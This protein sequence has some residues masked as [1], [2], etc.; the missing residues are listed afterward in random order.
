MSFEARQ[1]DQNNAIARALD[2]RVSLIQELLD[3][4]R[5]SLDLDQLSARCNLSSSRLQHLFKQHTGT[6]LARYSKQAKLVRAR[7]LVEE[8]F[9]T[10]KQI[11]AIVGFS[12]ISHFVRDYKLRFGQTPSGT[13]RLSRP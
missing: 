5:Q 8:S 3:N 11:A 2:A 12:D 13:R 7:K 9:Y 6:T 1:I 10:V 4:G